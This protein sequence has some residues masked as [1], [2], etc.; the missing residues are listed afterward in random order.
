M[1]VKIGDL[2][3]KLVEDSLKSIKIKYNNG[4]YVFG[5]RITYFNGLKVEFIPYLV[6]D[7]NKTD[8]KK[9]FSSGLISGGSDCVG[10]KKDFTAD[11]VK[12]KLDST[13]KPKIDKSKFAGLRECVACNK[14][15]KVYFEVR[16]GLKRLVS[17]EGV[18]VGYNWACGDCYDK[19]FNSND[20]KLGD[21]L[22]K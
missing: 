4:V 3:V 21:N 12:I 15:L 19:V 2:P 18:L 10:L 22:K 8:L 6:V 7:D 1:V 9:S 5:K 20:L 17:D 13:F 14:K 11:I 16:G